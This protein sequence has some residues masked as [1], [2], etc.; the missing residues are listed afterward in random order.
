MKMK[1]YYFL[2]LLLMATVVINAQNSKSVLWYDSPSNDWYGALP[3]GNGRLGA[4]VFGDI[5]KEHL[6]LNDESLWAGKPEN[7]YPPNVREHYKTFQQLNFNGKFD[8]AR[9]YG[10]ENLVVKPTSIRPYEPLG[11]LYIAFNHKSK[12]SDYYRDLSMNEGMTT[13]SYSVDGKRF[14]RE[15]FISAEYDAIF[16]HFKSLDNVKTS[17][18]IY[19]D[20]FKDIEQDIDE[21]NILTIS[22]QIFDDEND[23]DD[24][25]DGSGEGGLHMK[26]STQIAIVPVDGKVRSVGNKLIIENSSEFTLVVTNTTDYNVNILNF[27]RRIDPATETHKILTRAM[28]EPYEKVRAKHIATHTKQFNTLS[29]KLSDIEIDEIPTDKRIEAAASGI[30]DNYLTQ[31]FFQYGRYLLLASSGNNAK[32]PANLQGIWNKDEWAAWESDFHLNINLQMNYWPADIC[33][34]SDTFDPLSNFMVVVAKAGKETAQNYLG[35]DGWMAHHV[36]NPFGRTTPSGSNLDSQFNNG[37][38]FPLAGTWMSLSLWRHYT[39]TLDKD[40]LRTTA[41]PVLKGAAKFALDFLIENK[42]GELITSPSYSPENSYVNPE[43]GKAMQNTISA[44]MDNQ[45]LR[46]L[47]QACIKSEEILGINEMKGSLRQALLKLPKNKIGADGTIQEWYKDFEEVEPEHR[48]ISHLFG[49]YP[50]NQITKKDVALF[51]AAKNTIDKRLASGGGLIGWSKAWAINFYARLFNSEKALESV[52]SLLA[53]QITTNMFDL[54]Y[55][56]SISERM[57][58]VSNTGNKRKIFQ[59][60]GNFGT[61]AGI[62]EMLL[63]S[64]EEGIIYLL[65]ALPK[66]WDSGSIKGIKARGNFELEMEWKNSKL[67]SATIV[68]HSGGKISMVYKGISKKMNLKLGESR[69]ISF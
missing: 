68:A 12:N 33:N 8:E 40:Y 54:I 47:F 17:A 62:A 59:I 10:M 28:G 67:T 39:F 21:D 25:V 57:G 13:V 46:E 1:K 58:T 63:Q 3:L 4:M 43:T 18:T 30:N 65:P 56:Q 23:F 44:T 53:S 11:D 6:Q 20:R 27:D 19:F 15:S 64:H 50:S 41:Y 36:L 60:E 31:L 9:D 14:S 48:H 26:F 49:L 35:S 61:T 52:N 34:L 66:E 7:P 2:P 22:G 5:E 55:P 37:Y 16:Y 45:I 69:K 29:L 38:C 51:E 32:L 42:D 24:N